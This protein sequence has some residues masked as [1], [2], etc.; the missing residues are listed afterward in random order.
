MRIDD[1]LFKNEVYVN[2]CHCQAVVVHISGKPAAT[3][4]KTW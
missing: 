3:L 4:G 2:D 1:T